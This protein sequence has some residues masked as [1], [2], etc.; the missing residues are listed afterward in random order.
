[1]CLKDHP[2]LPD[3]VR[4]QAERLARLGFSIN[5]TRQSSGVHRLSSEWSSFDR[6]SLASHPNRPHNSTKYLLL[7]QTVAKLFLVVHA[8]EEGE[9]VVSSARLIS[10][11]VMRT[12]VS[13][14]VRHLGGEDLFRRRQRYTGL[15]VSR[16]A[17]MRIEHR[18][19]RCVQRPLIV[20]VQT[21]RLVVLDHGR[22]VVDIL[23]QQIVDELLHAAR[24]GPDL[25]PC[26]QL[27]SSLII[28]FDEQTR[29]AQTAMLILHL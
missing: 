15:S 18:L 5:T 13:I 16:K 7:N 28:D 4:Y 24:V 17:E 3:L 8:A 26:N 29:F 20:D 22:M 11:V 1:M 2:K 12:V 19:G 9:H 14:L 6:L 21:L 27:D 23:L 25:L 10:N